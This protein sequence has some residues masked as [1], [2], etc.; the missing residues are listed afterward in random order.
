MNGAN[1]PGVRASQRCRVGSAHDSR[2]TI[3]DFTIHD[4]R[5]TTSIVFH[6]TCL[7]R[8]A[9][10]VV[11]FNFAILH[12]NIPCLRRVTHGD[13]LQMIEVN[14]LLRNALN[15]VGTYSRNFFR[16]SVPVIGRKIIKLLRDDVL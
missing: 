4:L 14:V 9:I 5:F 8:L 7:Q 3:H 12:E 16:V 11:N 1:E 6:L 15:V 2:S 10:D 13:N